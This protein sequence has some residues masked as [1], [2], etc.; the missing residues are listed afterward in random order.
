MAEVARLVGMEERQY[1]KGDKPAVY[2]GLHMVHV[3]DTVEDVLGCKV[4]VV[5]CPQKLDSKSLKIGKLY[6]LEYQIYD[7]RNGKAARLVGLN[8]VAEK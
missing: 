2:C 5:S 4:E 3:Q 1:M 6:Q 8:E 7:T